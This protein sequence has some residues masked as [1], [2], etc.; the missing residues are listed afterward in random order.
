[1]LTAYMILLLLLSTT[2]KHKMKEEDRSIVH[3]LP[4]SSKAEQL[5]GAPSSAASR[6]PD[7]PPTI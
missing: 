6:S 4:Q 5:S 3:N 7:Q 1:M 2:T